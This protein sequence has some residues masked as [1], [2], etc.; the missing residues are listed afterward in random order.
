MTF[1]NI[2]NINNMRMQNSKSVAIQA[3]R[4]NDKNRK[5]GLHIQDFGQTVD[6]E[7]IKRAFAL[8]EIE[9]K[10]K[11]VLTCE[12]VGSNDQRRS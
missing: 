2:L 11:R 9:L 3:T 10:N 6:P 5:Y 7:N 4:Y 1:I 8:L 12:A